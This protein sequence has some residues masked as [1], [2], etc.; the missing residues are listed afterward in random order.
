MLRIGLASLV[1]LVVLLCDLR[2][3]VIHSYSGQNILSI[4]LSSLKE[5]AVVGSIQGLSF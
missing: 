2:L 4:L 5:C 3:E 1:I